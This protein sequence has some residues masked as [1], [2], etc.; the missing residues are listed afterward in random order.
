MTP[1]C[2]MTMT[3]VTYKPS[4]YL[5]IVVVSVPKYKWRFHSILMYK[6][7][8]ICV[9]QRTNGV[10]CGFK[11]YYRIVRVAGS[12]CSAYTAGELLS[13]LRYVNMYMF[14]YECRMNMCK[15][16]YGM[17][18]VYVIVLSFF[19]GLLFVF[20]FFRFIFFLAICLV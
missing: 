18:E 15:V 9:P 8:Y 1:I 13:I 11:W 20:F 2:A 17:Y 19:F 7:P 14:S 4:L 10:C 12:L 16:W 6:R 5:G 3:T